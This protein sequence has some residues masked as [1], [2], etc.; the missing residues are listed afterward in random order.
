[1]TDLFEKSIRTLE[2]PA[3][4][5][6]LAAKAVSDAAKERCLRL[7]P[8][9]DTQEVLHLLD[10]TDA[11]KERLGLHGSP[12]FSGVK[13]VSA[14]LTRAD[15]GGMLNTRE[16]LDVAGVLTAS[17]RV[18]EYDAQRQGEATV[19][20]R[21]F[22]SLHTNRYLEDKIRSA[23]LDEETIADTA[24]SELADIR[25]KMRL[26]ATK[27]RQI[28]QRIISSP[29]YAKVLQEALITQRDGRFVVPVKAE[30]KGSL[31]GLVHDISSSGATLF[32]EP[33]GVVQANNELKE[34]E[35]REQKEIDRILRQLSAECAG[36]M[37]N[38][39]WDYD[40]LVQL[41]VIF[42]RAQLSY[43]LNAS[44]PEVRRRGGITLRRARHPLLDQ[45]KAVPIT[46][47][48]GEQ[49]DTLVITG[50][51]TGG[52]TVTLKTIGLLS[53]MAQCGLH[54][55]ADGGSAVRVF[56]RVLADVGDEQSIEQSLSTFSAH[57]VNIVEILKEA[58][59]HSLVLFDELGAGTDP[60]E[61]AA[62]AIAIIQE[63][64]NQGA[65]IAATTHYAELK[66]FA[67]TT[68]GVENASCEFDVETLCPTYKLLIG[69]PGKSNAFAIAARLGLQPVIIDRAKEQV[70]T[71][72][73]RFEDV[74][75]ELERERRRIEKMKEEAQRMRSA[76][77]SE[78]DK[79]RAERDAAEERADKMMEGARSQADNILKNA[80]MTAET[81]FDELETL[82][83]QSQKKASEQNLAAAKAALRGVITQTE[84]EQRRGIQKR[85]VDAEEVRPLAKGDR[86]RLLNVGGVIATV[87]AAPDRDG[88]V[89]VQAGPMKMTV[90]VNEVRLV[91]E[92]KAAPKPKMQ[93]RRDAPRRELNLRSAESEVDVRGMSA[94]EALFEVDN[95]LSRAIMAGLPA[96]TV[97]HGKGTGVLRKAVQDEL[98]RNRCVKR[99]RLG[100]YGE[101]E[102]G[103]TIAELA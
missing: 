3:V 85:V 52:K 49:F 62:L 18:S 86:V 8:A 16:L 68:A 57:M 83:K 27:G 56:R 66:T 73:A 54:I 41:D 79:M 1:M 6:K 38:I 55:P 72:D 91:E 39:L 90:K 15:H 4:L 102:D 97:I 19:L 17:R 101:G 84:N 88:S 35:A 21:L 77:Q 61:G 67:M 103:V 12:S 80:R 81:V 50:P 42:A 53:L 75:A 33:M 7:T 20:D 70:S 13:D 98:K 71:E 26:A 2:L 24:S 94:E 92:K 74:L 40:I 5:E 36:Q 64:R 46:V 60:V 28:L 59:R 93:P 48:L 58:D 87:L 95:F 69:I 29:S 78:R 37:E 9:T 63:A 32:V 30:C 25:R 89:Q 22:S 96:V 99:Y 44:R 100:V 51:N 82:K 34:L 14:A 65:L 31:P 47:E 76:A 11:A 45:A 23:I 10:E 43:Q